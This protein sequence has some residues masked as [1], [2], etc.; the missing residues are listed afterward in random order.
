MHESDLFIFKKFLGHLAALKAQNIVDPHNF[1]YINSQEE[2]W[3]FEG[4]P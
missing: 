3:V 2:P 1:V 4:G